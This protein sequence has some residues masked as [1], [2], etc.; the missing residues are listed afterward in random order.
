MVELL[1]YSGSSLTVPNRRGQS[2]LV[3]AAIK[4]HQDIVSLIASHPLVPPSEVRNAILAFAAAQKWTSEE[5]SESD[6]GLLRQP[7]S[8]AAPSDAAAAIEAILLRA[9]LEK[10][11]AQRA[12]PV[13]LPRD[14][15]EDAPRRHVDQGSDVSDMAEFHSAAAVVGRAALRAMG[16]RKYGAAVVLVFPGY[17]VVEA[18]YILFR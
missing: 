14:P 17:L 5:P 6:S 16:K 12:R 1:V 4:G 9:L 2:P 15:E 13:V 18:G 3:V 8:L 11:P 10:T 7:G